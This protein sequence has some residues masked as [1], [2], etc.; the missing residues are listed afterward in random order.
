[1]ESG[2]PGLQISALSSAAAWTTPGSSVPGLCLVQGSASHCGQVATLAAAALPEEGHSSA[3][4]WGRSQLTPS[5]LSEA[6]GPS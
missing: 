5:L 2:F 6:P 3:W 4:G 1:M